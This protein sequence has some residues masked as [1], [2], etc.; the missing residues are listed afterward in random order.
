MIY[1]MES[2]W[3]SFVRMEYGIWDGH[4]KDVYQSNEG[5]DPMRIIGIRVYCAV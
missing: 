1:R 5:V 4:V 3:R 2:Q